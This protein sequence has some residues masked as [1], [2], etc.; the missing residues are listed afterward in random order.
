MQAGKSPESF[1]VFLLLYGPGL[2]VENDVRSR[3]YVLALA[4]VD[5]VKVLVVDDLALLR[6]VLTVDG[7]G[8]VQGHVGACHLK[9]KKKNYIFHTWQPS[10]TDEKGAF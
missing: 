4:K 3:G 1:Y 5:G 6:V 9:I 10:D 2:I 7:D 8:V